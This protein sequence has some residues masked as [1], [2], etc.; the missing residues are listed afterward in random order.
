MRCL[1]VMVE[2]VSEVDVKTK[3]VNKKNKVSRE[4][5]PIFKVTCKVKPHIIFY[6]HL[7]MYIQVYITEHVT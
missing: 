5:K 1:N 7:F 6:I 2:G 4:H 3:L